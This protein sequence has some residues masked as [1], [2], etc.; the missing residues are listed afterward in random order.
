[1]GQPVPMLQPQRHPQ[2]SWGEGLRPNPYDWVAGAGKASCPVPLAGGAAL[3]GFHQGVAAMTIM[4]LAAVARRSV[5][6]RAVSHE[7]H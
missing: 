1:M 2:P 5:C 3:V 7:E 6:R 4:D